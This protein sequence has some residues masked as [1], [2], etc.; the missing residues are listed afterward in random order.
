MVL[1]D[2]VEEN[3]SGIAVGGLG[4]SFQNINEMQRTMF[5]ARPAIYKDVAFRI[6]HKVSCSHFLRGKS[7]KSFLVTWYF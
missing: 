5:N 1:L 3:T 2:I 4:G 7:K 6:Q